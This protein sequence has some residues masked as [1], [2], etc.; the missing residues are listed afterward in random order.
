[1]IKAFVDNTER[2]INSLYRGSDKIYRVYQGTN[3]LYSGDFNPTYDISGCVLNIDS[4]KFT[5]SDNAENEV[6][7][8]Y[9]D[10]IYQYTSRPFQSASGFGY[11]VL[12]VPSNGNNE[13][14]YHTGRNPSFVNYSNNHTDIRHQPQTLT[15]NLTHLYFQKYPQGFSRGLIGGSSLNFSPITTGS[16]V[17]CG[18]TY[19]DGAFGAQSSFGYALSEDDINYFFGGFC[20]NTALTPLDS[21]TIIPQVIFHDFTSSLSPINHFIN[22]G[23]S[24]NSSGFMEGYLF[25]R[26]LTA[27]E[28]TD[29]TNYLKAKWGF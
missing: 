26:H 10:S 2:S 11:S 13:P 23:S 7:N 27:G 5:Y 12:A 19:D 4:S 1:M 25:N 22:I 14:M 20:A 24:F 18:Y 15:K 9:W 17:F 16:L 6:A 8:S 21:F 3:L 28:K 29:I